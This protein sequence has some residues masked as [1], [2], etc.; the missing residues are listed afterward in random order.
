MSEPRPSRRNLLKLFGASVAAA[1]LP[2]EAGCATHEEA[3]AAS[4]SAALNAE[5]FTPA[6]RR[7]LATL[8]NE[9][10]PPDD[11]PGGAKLGAVPYIERLL[12]ALDGEAPTLWCGGPYSGRTADPTTG[13][14]PANGFK[15][16]LP[17]DRVSLKVWRLFLYGSDAVGGGPNDAV[18]GKTAGLRNDFKRNLAR[19]KDDPS[20]DDFEDEFRPIFIDLV[21]QAALGPPEYGGN[22]NLLGWK[23]LSAFDG[24]SA[25]LGFSQLDERTNTFLERPEAPLSTKNPGPDPEPMSFAMELLL[26]TATAFFDGKV[27]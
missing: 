8:A 1:G 15:E 26:G 2:L 24:D 4:E 16:N 23:K 13:V 25:P 17:L 20:I 12:T 11:L 7:V 9:V 14:R 3:G 6:E 21:S 19:L 27:F 10:L 18:L 22:P 5:F